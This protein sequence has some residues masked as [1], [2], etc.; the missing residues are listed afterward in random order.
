MVI[1]RQLLLCFEICLAGSD[2]PSELRDEFLGKLV[3]L[4]R[5]VLVSFRGQQDILE[6]VPVEVGEIFVVV[7]CVV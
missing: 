2:P 6:G 3:K 7:G 1:V 5:V 4:A